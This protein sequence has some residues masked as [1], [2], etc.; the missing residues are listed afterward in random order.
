MASTTETP[1]AIGFVVAG[2]PSGKVSAVIVDDASGK[3]VWKILGRYSTQLTAFRY[4]ETP[5]GF[6]VDHAAESLRVGERY[7]VEV[8]VAGP[9]GYVRFVIDA[10]GRAMAVE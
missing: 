1:P 7:R 10:R 6:V 3:I 5:D 9:D 2:N 4:G 8:S